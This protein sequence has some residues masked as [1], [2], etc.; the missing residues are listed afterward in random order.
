MAT[1]TGLKKF[2]SSMKRALFKI[3][4]KAQM[5]QLGNL[6]IGLIHDRTRNK[7]LGVKKP[8]GNR[9]KL[10]K[11]SKKY[12]EW[13]SKQPDLHPSAASGTASNLTFTGDMLD[14]L[15]VKTATKSRLEIGHL[16]DKDAKK[17]IAQH[18]AGRQF[19]FLGK[20]EVR[21]LL[22]KFNEVVNKISKTI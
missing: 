10:K 11:V 7:G 14:N 9:T 8:E 3:S 22:D 18:A 20:V 19:L 5:T 21:Q 16:K 2:D 17:A 1:P 13:R 4:S 6:T 12:A 15:V